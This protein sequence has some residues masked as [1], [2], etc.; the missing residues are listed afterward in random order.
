M[1]FHRFV[2]PAYFG[3]PSCPVAPAVVPFNGVNYN[4]FNVT[5]GGIG[6][7]GSALMSDAKPSGVNTGTYAVAFGEDA[8]STNLNRGY[9]ALVEN[10][11]TIDDWLHRD[12]ATPVR[13]ANAV[14]G[15]PVSSIVLPANTYVGG[16]G[17]YAL[18][19][20][21]SILNSDG[22]EILNGDNKVDVASITGATIGDGFSAGAVTLNLSFSIPTSTTYYVVYG[23]RSNLATLPAD[24]LISVGVRASEEVAADVRRMIAYLKGEAATAWDANPTF[25]T[26]SLGAGGLNSLYRRSSSGQGYS[27]NVDVTATTINTPGAGAEVVADGRALTSAMYTAYAGFSASRRSTD[28]GQALFRAEDG[29]P[30]GGLGHIGFAAMMAGPDTTEAVLP[31]AGGF[32]S[33]RRMGAGTYSVVSES[34]SATMSATAYTEL[35]DVELG[36]ALAGGPGDLLSAIR[37]GYDLLRVRLPATIGGLSTLGDRDISLRIVAR[38]ATNVTCCGLDGFLPTQLKPLAGPITVT[39]LGWYSAS[40]VNPNGAASVK[41]SL[42]PTQYNNNL[43]V[44][45]GSTVFLSQRANDAAQLAYMTEP[46]V[47]VFGSK[48]QKALE[49][50]DSHTS[51]TPVVNGALVD[52][53]SIECKGISSTGSISCTGLTSTG[54]VNAGGYQVTALTAIF[55]DTTV[56]GI[57]GDLVASMTG[58]VQGSRVRPMYN[59]VPR[60]I[61]TWTGAGTGLFTLSWDG[62]TAFTP[63]ALNADRTSHASPA[64]GAKFPQHVFVNVLRTGG[65][66]ANPDINIEPPWRDVTVGEEVSIT[67]LLT[68]TAGQDYSMRI[69][70]HYRTISGVDYHCTCTNGIGDAAGP[71]GNISLI[72]NGSTSYVRRIH[73]IVLRCIYSG[74]RADNARQVVWAL[75]SHTRQSAL[76]APTSLF[77]PNGSMDP[78]TDV[79]SSTAAYGTLI[80]NQG[81]Y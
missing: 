10:T 39:V 3:A 16:S 76:D 64:Q 81:W 79:V 29:V 20:L 74:P 13:T 55:G 67:V 34:A 47:K 49:W 43:A 32:G 63:G 78:A 60:H 27:A 31:S 11:D 36:T 38:G 46:A 58:L 62:N 45:D 68:H 59:R 7:G 70:Q 1:P 19:V 2:Q 44:K 71:G 37:C 61:A 57:R 18:D 8:T 17:G 52:D 80:L 33:Y 35:V 30:V 66:G 14:A 72:E 24:A 75:I 22:E 40:M 23:T 12:I 4:L 21:F 54:N 77:Y 42:R 6:A 25:N 51:G 73:H 28:P 65:A 50:G 53:G 15:A 56:S 9:R 5:S 41:Y 26:W 69:A 48:W